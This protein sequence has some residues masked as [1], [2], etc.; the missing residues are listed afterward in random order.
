MAEESPG[1][2]RKQ[3]WVLFKSLACLISWERVKAS[4]LKGHC[5]RGVQIQ[6][7]DWLQRL[8]VVT[9]D[10]LAGVGT[11]VSV[12]SSFPLLYPQCGNGHCSLNR[13]RSPD[14]PYPEWPSVFP[15]VHWR[16]V[17]VVVH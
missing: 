2:Q 7:E 17:F 11:L 13:R 9:W 10:L 5:L 8:A 3:L 16:L 12:T 6:G 1:P 15:E 4:G 14:H